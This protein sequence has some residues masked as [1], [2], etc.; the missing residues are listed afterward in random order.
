[1]DG[2]SMALLGCFAEPD[3]FPFLAPLQCNSFCLVRLSGKLGPPPLSNEGKSGFFSII[4][5]LAK[6]DTMNFGD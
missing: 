3:W 2:Y 6:G 5:Y 1:M 4:I